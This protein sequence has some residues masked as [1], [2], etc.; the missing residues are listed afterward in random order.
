[1]IE[2]G[3][4]IWGLPW[5]GFPSWLCRVPTADLC[6][7]S[8]GV[9]LISTYCVPGTGLDAGQKRPTPFRSSSS[10]EGE[11]LRVLDGGHLG[12]WV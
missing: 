1:M 3:H 2:G 5:P 7:P 11:A 12:M 8:F 10:S 4:R 6:F 9:F